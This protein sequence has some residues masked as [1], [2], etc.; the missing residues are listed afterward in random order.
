M[1]FFVMCD[2]PI[3]RVVDSSIFTIPIFFN[4]FLCIFHFNVLPKNFFFCSTDWNLCAP[5][6]SVCIIIYLTNHFSIMNLEII[7]SV[8][9]AS[10]SPLSFHNA[11]VKKK[12]D[13]S[14]PFRSSLTPNKTH[15]DRV[16]PSAIPVR[17]HCRF[18]EHQESRLNH[19]QLRQPSAC[20]SR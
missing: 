16:Q 20:G 7:V 19:H 6:D 17:H 12:G 2:Q 18:P 1:S 10:E 8:S 15:S 9:T 5:N 11:P 3:C 13:R 14:P 4:G